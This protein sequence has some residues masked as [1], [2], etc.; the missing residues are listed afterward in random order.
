MK[1]F[2][3]VPR[4]AMWMVLKKVGCTETFV[5]LLR[6]LHDDIQCCVVVNG[7]KSDFGSATCGVNQGCVLAPP[8]CC[9]PNTLQ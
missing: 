1:A 6:L 7:E 8:Q 2:D 3:G 5:G 4:E 9:S